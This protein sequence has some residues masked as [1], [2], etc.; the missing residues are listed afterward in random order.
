[1]VLWSLMTHSGLDVLA[2]RDSVDQAI[3][4]MYCLG[5]EALAFGGIGS[6]VETP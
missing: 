6:L 2:A 4:G 1:M 5:H 3:A